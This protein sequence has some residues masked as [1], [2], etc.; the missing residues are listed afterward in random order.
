MQQQQQDPTKNPTTTTNVQ[1]TYIVRH[2]AGQMIV[3]PTYEVKT[4][5]SNQPTI[6][7]HHV[8]TTTNPSIIKVTDTN[9]YIP[10]GKEHDFDN[11]KMGYDKNGCFI[12]QSKGS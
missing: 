7:T 4:N 11:V 5:N 3:Y 8:H 2:I 6:K 1:P 9:V 10:K 12:V